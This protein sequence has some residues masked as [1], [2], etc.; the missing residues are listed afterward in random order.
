VNPRVPTS[1][2]LRD[3]L[4][5]SPPEQVSLGWVIDR[6]GER[7]FGI[8]MLFS[9]VIA[10]VPGFSTFVG[11]LVAVPA[12]QMI[13]ARH[14]PMLPRFFTDR[15]FPTRRLA[16]LIERMV[17]LLV[18]AEKL[19][20]PRWATPFHATKRVVGVV[21]LVLGATLVLPFP[22]NH[23]IPSLVIILIAHAYLEEDGVMLCFALVVTQRGDGLGHDQRHSFP[24]SP[25]VMAS[26]S[27]FGKDREIARKRKSS[28]TDEFQLLGRRTKGGRRIS[29]RT[30]A[31]NLRQWATEGNA[32]ASREDRR[33]AGRASMKSCT[34][35]L[36]RLLQPACG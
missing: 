10:L 8:L 25:F 30:P 3:I 26:R 35:P 36:M 2:V 24:G 1:A 5:E 32:G 13:V 4:A 27:T 17:P 7:S 20:Q 15:R 28:L 34:S 22:F 21:I 6:L 29:R 9:G 12:I 33:K 14:G 11:V 31:P 23:V 16:R 18:R 19:L